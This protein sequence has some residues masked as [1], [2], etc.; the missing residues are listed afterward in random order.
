MAMNWT[1][2]AHFKGIDL[3]DS[4]VL[5]WEFN[6]DQLTLK[7]EASIWPQSKYYTKPKNDEFT[8]YRNAQ[9]SFYG[10][11]NI[12]G[13]LSIQSVKPTIDPDGS[14]DYG[15]IESLAKTNNGFNLS[16]EFGVVKITGGELNFEIYT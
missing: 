11:K 8:C 14:A 5:G 6:K 15:N 3:N 12:E 16:G 9:I 4:F 13:L 2:I 10:V 1:E 7:I